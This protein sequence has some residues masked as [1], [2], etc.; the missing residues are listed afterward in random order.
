MQFTLLYSALGFRA[1]PYEGWSVKNHPVRSTALMQAR[2]YREFEELLRRVYSFHHS[3]LR[4]SCMGS[5]S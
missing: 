4:A 5:D 2:I 3:A 1:V